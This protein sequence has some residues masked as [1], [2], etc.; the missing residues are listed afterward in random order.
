MN[1]GKSTMDKWVRQ[2]KSERNGTLTLP[3]AIT[4]EQRKTQELENA[5]D[6]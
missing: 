1:V 5:L 3:N 4:L 6:G 2:L